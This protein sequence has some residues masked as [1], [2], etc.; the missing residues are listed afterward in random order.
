MKFIWKTETVPNVHLETFSHSL[1]KSK[2]CSTSLLATSFWWLHRFLQERTTE[3]SFWS[4][5]WNSAVGDFRLTK[6]EFSFDTGTKQTK[7]ESAKHKHTSKACLYQRPRL[8]SRAMRWS[9]GARAA[10]TST[11]LERLHR[12]ALQWP[13]RR[14]QKTRLLR[15]SSS[16]TIM[17]APQRR[18]A[19]PPR[20]NSSKVQ[21]EGAKRNN[22]QRRR[23]AAWLSRRLPLDFVGGRR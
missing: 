15:S 13:A 17:R 20:R 9:S 18:T 6:L 21:E 16:L 11:L 1:R 12:A 19:R 2:T 10:P 4:F 14:S 7:T 5:P 8:R 3:F 22:L 23:A